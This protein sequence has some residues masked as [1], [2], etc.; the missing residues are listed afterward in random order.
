MLTAFALS[1]TVVA[2]GASAVVMVER[3][4]RPHRL[5][6]KP[7]QRP[8]SGRIMCDQAMRIGVT[9][10]VGADPERVRYPDVRFVA[11]LSDELARRLGYA[12]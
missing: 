3:I 11:L 12:E 8:S 6:L 2:I 10:N 5:L 9:A 1:V 4:R 7:P